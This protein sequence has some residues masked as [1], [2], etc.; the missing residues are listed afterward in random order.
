MHSSRALCHVP[1]VLDPSVNSTKPPN[2]PTISSSSH[3]ESG[4]LRANTAPQEMNK[5]NASSGFISNI[6]SKK[7][8]KNKGVSHDILREY[9]LMAQKEDELKGVDELKGLI[10]PCS[11]IRPLQNKPEA[12]VEQKPFGSNNAKAKQVSVKLAPN[13][14]QIP[15]HIYRSD[16]SRTISSYVTEWECGEFTLKDESTADV[17]GAQDDRNYQDDSYGQKERSESSTE[18]VR[19]FIADQIDYATSL[20]TQDPD[21]A[22]PWRRWLQNY[23]SVSIYL[24]NTVHN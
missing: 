2:G 11:F 12:R 7:E 21:L 8:K 20:A 5:K 18:D 1:V 22:E 3:G 4:I 24:I 16:T 17:S 10:Q 6:F 13:G 23:A 19:R 14:S 9:Q 15:G